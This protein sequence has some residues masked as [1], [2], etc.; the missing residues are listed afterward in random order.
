M[1]L[2][3]MVIFVKALIEAMTCSIT[4]CECPNLFVWLIFMITTTRFFCKNKILRNI[5]MI[6][7]FTID[8][9]TLFLNHIKVCAFEILML[10][11]TST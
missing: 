4:L 6:A 5:V 3:Q 10:K 1:T 8:K 11:V 2:V 9:L 7:F